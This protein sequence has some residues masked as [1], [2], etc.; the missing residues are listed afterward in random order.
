M[1]KKSPRKEATEALSAAAAGGQLR[2]TYSI[3]PVRP[4]G[5]D[6]RLNR[7]GGAVGWVEGPGE[8][9]QGY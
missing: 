1:K 9:G 8:A 4:E 3:T 6:L 2:H 7:A 5:S